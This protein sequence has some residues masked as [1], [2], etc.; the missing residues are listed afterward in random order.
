MPCVANDHTNNVDQVGCFKKHLMRVK[1]QKNI[2]DHNSNFWFKK[3]T[4]KRCQKKHLGMQTSCIFKWSILSQ[5]FSGIVRVESNH[6]LTDWLLICKRFLFACCIHFY[7]QTSNQSNTKSEFVASTVHNLCA[8]FIV[9]VFNNFQGFGPN[10]IF[11]FKIFFSGWNDNPSLKQS[12]IF[13]NKINLKTHIHVWSFLQFLIFC[14][15]TDITIFSILWTVTVCCRQFVSMFRK[16][17]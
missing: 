14:C 11:P 4:P 3:F 9:I 13:R 8:K 1:C 15:R 12:A 16:L 6:R 17:S 2:S 10:L 7:S 5:S